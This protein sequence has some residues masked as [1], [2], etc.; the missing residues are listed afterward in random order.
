MFDLLVCDCD[1][2]LVVSEVIAQRALVGML[3][4]A[5]PALDPAAVAQTIYGPICLTLFA[6]LQRRFRIALP[7]DLPARLARRVQAELVNSRAPIAGLR[8]ALGRVPLPAAA[9]SNWGRATFA[10]CVERAGVA[11]VFGARLFSAEDAERPKPHADVHLHA[12]RAL[13]AEP[14]RCLA[15]A[16][17][18]AGLEAAR[19]A[20]MTTVAFVG[21]SPRP[22]S[23]ARVLRQLGVSRIISNIGELPEFVSQGMRGTPP[24]VP[25]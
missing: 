15:V 16:D 1:G 8:E 25:R 23:Y 10:G 6:E 13:G 4:D 17:N 22:E 5:F 18:I 14:S 19:A 11:G 9:V 12:A 24:S 7:A 3:C 20:G 2:A 21:A